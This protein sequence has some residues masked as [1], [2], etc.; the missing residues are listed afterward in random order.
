MTNSRLATAGL[1]FFLATLMSPESVSA[2]QVWDLATD[3]SDE[4]NPNGPWSYNDPDG[5]PI[6][7]HFDDWDPL[8]CCFLSAQPAWTVTPWPGAGHEVLWFKTVAATQTWLD[9][10]QGT[11]GTHGVGGGAAIG[12]A[13][14]SPIAG[15]V[16]ISGNTWLARRIGRN[17]TWTLS[18]N[19][20]V[21]TSGVVD[22][23]GSFTS[24]HPFDFADGSGGAAA[25]NAVVSI[26][27]RIELTYATGGFGE[28]VGTN[29]RIT[30]GSQLISEFVSPSIGGDT[31]HVT[32]RLIGSGFVNGA[33]ISLSRAGFSDIP[34]SPISVGKNG[35]LT[36]TFDLTGQAR[37]QWNVVVTE[38]GGN[39]V[40]LPDAFTIEAGRAPQ[41]WVDIVGR[42]ALRIGRQNTLYVMVGNSGNVDAVGAH[43]LLRIPEGVQHQFGTGEPVSSLP[44]NLAHIISFARLSPGEVVAPRLTLTSP[45]GTSLE[46]SAAVLDDLSRVISTRFEPDDS[47]PA[48]AAQAVAAQQDLPRLTPQQRTEQER[49]YPK[50]SSAEEA[51]PGYVVSVDVSLPGRPPERQ[52]GISLGGGK[53]RWVYGGLVNMGQEVDIASVKADLAKYGAVQFHAALRPADNFGVKQD[54]NPISLEEMKEIVELQTSSLPDATGKEFPLAD[55]KFATDERIQQWAQAH[56]TCASSPCSEEDLRLQKLARF[57]QARLKEGNR[58]SSWPDTDFID[59]FQYAKFATERI[60]LEL[61]FRYS[62][63]HLSR[64]DSHHSGELFVEL[65]HKANS[66]PLQSQSPVG[67]SALDLFIQW[68]IALVGSWDPNDKTGSLG[69]GQQQYIESHQPLRYHVVFE[70][71]ESATAPAQEVLITDQLD[72]AKMD[73]GT[74]SLGPITF[75]HTVVVPPLGLRVYATTVDLRPAKQL[76][77]NIEGRLD[78]QSGL[79]TWRF[80]SLDPLTGLPPDDPFAG[81]LPP[82]LNPPEGDG[83]VLFTVMPKKDLVTGTE[84]RNEASIVFDTNAP[85]LTP[86]WLNTLDN[87]TPTSHVAPLPATQSSLTFDVQ[88][89]GSDIGAGL[90]DFTIYVSDNG[91]P[92][93]VALDHTTQT[94]APF[95][96]VAGHTYAFYSLARDLLG[97]TEPPKSAAEATTHVSVVPAD[98]TFCA[99]EGGVCAFSGTTEVRYGA[100]GVYVYL[101][102][103]DGTACNNAVFGDPVYGTRKACAIRIAPAPTEWTFC[104]D[105]GDLCPFTGTAEVRY[106]ANG[107]YVYQTLTDGTACIND[108]FGDPIYG[109][110]KACAIRI[111]PAP[112]EWTFCAAEGGVCAFSGTAEVR[113]GAN[114]AYVYQ[115]FLN[116]TACANEV[117]GDPIYG[118]VKFCNRRTASPSP[119]PR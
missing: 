97:H 27:D 31:G 77:V 99:P 58:A 50:S 15:R 35:T 94:S 72:T 14:T 20:R 117:F 45:F 112:T 75:G 115:T 18:L 87:T 105:E 102:L 65:M 7:L 83:S 47:A 69:V 24:G 90:R 98:W 6:P 78:D 118:V 25:L 103:T 54:G 36:T 88:W 76:L 67:A 26:G 3:W 79:L 52:V 113:Y 70:N 19:G 56:L 60:F 114:G 71:V 13:W 22:S 89:S 63:L 74:L 44:G 109:T 1:M 81:F 104:A 84:I 10:P 41:L 43:L 4:R 82:N 62:G 23:G 66:E 93:D 85:I 64:W 110:V 108:V 119:P 95:T 34:G 42:A 21:L 55:L 96:G 51:P 57:F 80:S 46:I 12:V 30:E 9:L 2:Q 39:T 28:F 101:T 106:G 40:T 29:L 8:R 107:A 100:S 5:N 17:Q 59:C 92:F 91:G 73:I 11:V 48:V 53:V 33:S 38:P 68:L 32:V 37:G 111:P 16:V 61:E 49:L 86:S 116:G